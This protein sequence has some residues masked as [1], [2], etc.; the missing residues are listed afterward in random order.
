MIYVGID[1]SKY[2]HDCCIVSSD[3]EIIESDMIVTNDADGFTLLE[4]RLSNL[5]REDSIKIGFEATGHYC[6]NLKLFLEKNH[7]SFMELNPLLLKQFIKSHSLRR[8]KTDSIDCQVI[9]R[10][11]MTVEYK[12]YP[13]EFYHMYCLKSLTRMREKMIRQRSR[14]LVQMTNVLD[15]MFPEFKPFFNGRFSEASL[16]L[17]EKYGTPEAISRITLKTYNKIHDL[18]RGRFNLEK[19]HTLKRLAK[20]TIG[21][22]NKVYELELK[23]L[24]ELYRFVNVRIQRFD[25]EISQYMSVLNPMIL[26]IPGIGM[27]SAACII[28]EYGDISRF[29]G[30]AAML[31]FAGMEPGYYQ[32]GTSEYEGH[33]V[34]R[35]SSYLRCAIYNVCL[36]LVNSNPV[37]SEY[38]HKKREE[39]KPYKVAISHVAKKLIRVIYALETQHIPYDPEKCR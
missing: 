12:P 31:S 8:T 15:H 34:K 20:N 38:Y 30:S 35:G 18:T 26:T 27:T 37:F 6:I 2:K 25:K 10:Y 29:S 21:E 13:T 17:L 5:A 23:T 28:A 22:S 11:L 9:A 4:S 19:Y 14:Y 24:L 39:G 36:P 7:H 16:Y 3:G 33:M 32:S 1:V